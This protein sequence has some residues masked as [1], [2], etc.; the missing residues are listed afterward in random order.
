MIQP[1]TNL[2]IVERVDVPQ[3]NK[4][5]LLSPNNIG[6]F[7]K[8][9]II[10]YGKSVR[11]LT[12]IDINVGDIVI[13]NPLPEVDKEEID[14]EHPNWKLMESRQILARII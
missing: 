9:K 12:G 10:A 2:V 6:R 13:S 4:G 11:E 8:V 7:W 5:I 14:S 3:N 1:A